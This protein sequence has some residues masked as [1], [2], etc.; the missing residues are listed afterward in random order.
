[1]RKRASS[2][3]VARL[4]EVSQ[5]TV[6]YVLSN[7]T[8][9]V[10][11][12]VTRSKVLAAAEKLSYMPNRL[13]DGILRGKT[14]TIGVLMS[15]FSNSFNSKI[16]TGMESG[17]A[18]AGYS[19]L[20]A[21]NRNDPEQERL[22]VRMLMEHRVAGIVAVSDEATVRD[23]PMWVEKAL[24]LDVDVC[25][26]DDSSLDGMVDT[27]VSDDLEGASLAV[28]HLVSQGHERIAFLGGSDRTTTSRDR[29]IGYEQAL[30]RHGLEVDSSLMIGN[31]YR[32]DVDPDLSPLILGPNRAT[33][34]FGVSDGLVGQAMMR[35]ESEGIY[36]RD[37]LAYVGYGNLEFSRYL[38]LSTIEQYPIEMGRRAASRMIA[39]IAGNKSN[40]TTD[41]V[42]PELVIRRS[43]FPPKEF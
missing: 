39:R 18:E 9:K 32:T 4:A 42:K 3:D 11:S 16:L 28:D 8:D 5:A 43:S 21:H 17:F 30:R 41:R 12:E 33:A 15:D 29:R 22:Q 1:V 35:L 37:I 26:V 7:R 23:L 10:I 19:I 27:V 36:R 20:I 34:V 38:W 13:A 31:H 6:S 14:L 40:P 2:I 24:R 25:V